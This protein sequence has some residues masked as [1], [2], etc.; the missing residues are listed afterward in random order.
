[1]IMLL[2]TSG[3]ITVDSNNGITGKIIDDKIDQ[4]VPVVSFDDPIFQ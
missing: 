3:R 4:D 2:A 1:M